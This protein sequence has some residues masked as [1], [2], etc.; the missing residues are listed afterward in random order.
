[1]RLFL[2][3]LVSLVMVGCASTATPIDVPVDIV[4]G[5]DVRD[6]NTSIT[7]SVQNIV[8]H[9]EWWHMATVVGLAWLVGWL[10]P[11]PMEMIR[12]F[13]SGLGAVITGFRGLW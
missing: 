2:L 10:S 4:T 1:M 3:V 9:L 5:G 7:T 8:S 11:G 13:F 6:V 12:G